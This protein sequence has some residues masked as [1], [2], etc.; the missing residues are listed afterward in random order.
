[1]EACGSYIDNLQLP[2]VLHTVQSAVAAGEEVWQVFVQAEAVQPGD[3]R[4]AAITA[5]RFHLRDNKK[6]KPWWNPFQEVIKRE[7]FVCVCFFW[8]PRSPNRTRNLGSNLNLIL[9][10][11]AHLLPPH[12]QCKNKCSHEAVIRRRVLIICLNCNEQDKS[13]AYYSLLTSS[14]Y[15]HL[16]YYLTQSLQY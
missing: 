6:K 16:F 2:Q 12:L 3:K 4:G 15:L 11:Q 8:H 7:C 10:P 5:Q 13:I 14:H 9:R 1:M